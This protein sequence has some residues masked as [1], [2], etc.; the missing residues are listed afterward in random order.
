MYSCEGLIGLELTYIESKLGSLPDRKRIN[1]LKGMEKR[2]RKNLVNYQADG[3]LGRFL[4][5]LRKYQIR[6]ILAVRNL[7]KAAENLN[8]RE[9]AGS[10]L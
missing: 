5:E 10:Y 1:R 8:N 4:R 7:I 2:L 6:E 3:A 9:V